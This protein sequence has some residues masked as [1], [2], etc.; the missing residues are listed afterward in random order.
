MNILL[1]C[2]R[3]LYSG[4]VSELRGVRVLRVA[5]TLLAGL[6]ADPWGH[7]V[8]PEVQSAPDFRPTPVLQ[9]GLPHLSLEVLSTRT[10]LHG[11]ASVLTMKWCH[12]I[13]DG[14][15]GK[16]KP[17]LA[18][19][20]MTGFVVFFFFWLLEFG[21]VVKMAEIDGK[22]AVEILCIAED[23]EKDELLLELSRG[24]LLQQLR[25]GDMYYLWWVPKQPSM[26]VSESAA[27]KTFC[28]LQWFREE[29][30]KQPKKPSTFT[31]SN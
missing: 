12:L 27:D 4:P 17:R 8:G 10:P 29:K 2:N 11:G 22:D 13:L 31:F 19:N 6:R 28:A 23:E 18:H 16:K 24:F 5:C 25:S 14:D 26:P 15:L 1:L 9:A 7:G 21:V 20:I 3:L 30:K